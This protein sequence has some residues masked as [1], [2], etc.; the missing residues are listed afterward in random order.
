MN[1]TPKLAA[2]LV[3][4]QADMPAVHKSKTANVAMKGGGSFRYSYADLADVT[5]EAMP[6]LTHHG[7]A[8]LT[9]PYR[10]EGGDYE[11]HGVLIHT[12]G[13]SLSGSLPIMGRTAQ[14]IGSSLTYNR[15]YLL[16][17]LTGIVTDVDDDGA[18]APAKRT[19]APAQ[20][21]PEPAPE[22]PATRTMS[23][24]PKPTGEGI[25][26]PQLKMLQASFSE[27]GITQRDNRLRYAIYIIGRV[28]ES[29]KDL[30]K[31]EASKVID[32]LQEDIQHPD[33]PDRDFVVP[34]DDDEK[35]L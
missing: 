33:H 15:R 16:G 4:F 31:A 30:T 18:S 17:C 20:E 32:A 6:I 21:Q 22:M 34:S 3:A 13:E 11:L 7:L 14:E 2:A 19:R 35:L 27:A 12:S 28:I 1:E 8:F 9:R 25:T 26:E 23:R 24:K 10:T 29:S 5:K